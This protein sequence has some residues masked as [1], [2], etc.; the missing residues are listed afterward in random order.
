MSKFLKGMSLNVSLFKLKKQ[1]SLL[2]LKKKMSYLS[3]RMNKIKNPARNFLLYRTEI[4]KYI[5]NKM[6]KI[7]YNLTNKL[8]N[9]ILRLSK[10][11]IQFKSRRLKESILKNRS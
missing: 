3:S 6:F 1:T 7:L 8:S 9:N 11:R 5:K 2:K 10:N 4:R